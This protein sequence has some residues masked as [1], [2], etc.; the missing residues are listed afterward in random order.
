MKNII[1]Y[2]AADDWKLSDRL[3]SFLGF[4]K[5]PYCY[6]R[7]AELL[8]EL[9]GRNYVKYMVVDT[10]DLSTVSQLPI[11]L[12]LMKEDLSGIRGEDRLKEYS[13]LTVLSGGAKRKLAAEGAVV[14]CGFS[15]KDTVTF[16]SISP[17]AVVSIQRRFSNVS[18][19]AIEVQD[20]PVGQFLPRG[21]ERNG[22][23]EELAA[24]VAMIFCEE[25]ML[26]EQ[27]GQYE[28]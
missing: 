26:G 2:G 11:H 22:G 5:K 20:I 21:L 4:V 14:S 28:G 27:G 19:E 8:Q 3:A 17:E 13:C 12:I 16:S 9:H 18:G 23:Y 1:V 24:A 25:D 10:D 15:Q 7:G 6:L